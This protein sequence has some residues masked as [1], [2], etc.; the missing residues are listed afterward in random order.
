MQACSACCA[1][2]GHHCWLAVHRNK[3]C[4]QVH[5]H[6]FDQPS[7]LRQEAALLAQLQRCPTWGELRALLQLLAQDGKLARLADHLLPP[8]LS[9]AA[10]AATAAQSPAADLPARK[11]LR[12][13]A[14]V[15][16]EEGEGEE[17]GEEEEQR[18]AKRRKRDGQAAV[19][20][21]IKVRLTVCTAGR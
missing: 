8:E 18:Q 4:H 16:Y 2:L 13:R 1:C 10:A 14:A 15:K 19:G 11:R 6:A 3:H 7:R 20:R 17:D 5:R 12:A 9:A 21:C